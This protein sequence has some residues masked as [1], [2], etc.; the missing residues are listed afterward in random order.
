[1]SLT[2]VPLSAWRNARRI[3]SSLWPFFGIVLPSSAAA[4]DHTSGPSLNLCPAYFSGFGS[5]FGFWVTT[6][7]ARPI[8]LVRQSIYSRLARYEERQRRRAP[9]RVRIAN[10]SHSGDNANLHHEVWQR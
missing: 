9:S 8:S 5:L 6:K 3:C 1:M 4:Q 2:R 10:A 7:I